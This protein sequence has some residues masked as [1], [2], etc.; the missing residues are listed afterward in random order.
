VEPGSNN[1]TVALRVVGGDEKEPSAWR[2]NR[3]TL[4]LGDINTGTWLSRL[5]SL[6]SETVKF[7]HESQGTGPENDCTGEIQSETVKFG[8]ESRG[9]GPENDCT[10]ENQQQL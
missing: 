4:F 3:A 5:G 8:H 10:G 1:S 6:Q 7:G 2:Y 9:T